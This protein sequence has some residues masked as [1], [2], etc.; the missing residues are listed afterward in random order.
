MNPIERFLSNKI[1]ITDPPSMIGR[2]PDTLPLRESSR[3][4]I[5]ERNSIPLF[6]EM[7]SL[8]YIPA[9]VL[10]NLTKKYKS[11]YAVD[12]VSF[13]VPKGSTFG[14]LGGNG[15]GKTTTIAMI[16]GLVVPSCG[17]VTVLGHDMACARHNVLKR[18]NFQS[19]YVAMP[20]QLTVRQN[21]NVFGR[22]YC[23][24]DL[25][26]RIG[27]VVE[28]FGLGDLLNRE[29]ARL[30]A[31][32]KTRV[33]LAKAL[34]NS[35]EVLL[36]DEPTA[37]LDPDRSEWIRH[38]LQA[39]QRQHQAT[40]LLSSHNLIQVEQLCDYV[41]IMSY[42]RLAAIGTPA[43]LM[44]RYQCGSLQEVFLHISGVA[45]SW[46]EINQPAATSAPSPHETKGQPGPAIQH[47]IQETR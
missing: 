29:T 4:E 23:V 42:G 45:E 12:D 20:G 18:M 38:R 36:L 34:L 30:S 5:E 31:G 22:L 13:Y 6:S 1:E 40:I 28:E 7:T 47:I 39:Y 33:S 15:A 14:L 32:Q 19:P 44:W 27:Q 10:K 3:R 41:A 21:L 2:L 46:P 17:S 25:K 35:P 43:E 16:M 11:Y 26:A 8:E 37:S 24:P 9:I